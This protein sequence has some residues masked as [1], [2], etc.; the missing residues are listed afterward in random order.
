MTLSTP[1]DPALAAVAFLDM[2]GFTALTEIHGDQRAADLAEQFAAT[3]TA[4]LAPGDRMVKSL[5]DAVLL[6]APTPLA[7]L[8]L[9]RR[10]LE[11][12]TLAGELPLVR[13]GIHYGPVV[14]RHNDI[15]GS[16]VNRAARIA[17]AAE[18]HQILV[19]EAVA[20]AARHAGLPV[21]GLG[22]RTFRN[23]TEPMSIFALDVDCLCDQIDPICRIRVRPST[24]ARTI[25]YRG[26][27]FR[28]CSATC[29]DI[30]AADPSRNAT[31]ADCAGNAMIDFD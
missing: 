11:S 24:A 19:T 14:E 18:H 5:G 13:G 23:V 26:I 8:A 31:A 1:S 3:A 22:S 9:I 2:S 12:W 6:T 20:S 4:A 30:F 25:R 7:A 27:D 17:G 15:F 29:A 10:I 16:T 28:F 21:R